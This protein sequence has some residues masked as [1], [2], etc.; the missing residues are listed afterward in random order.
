MEN[1]PNWLKRISTSWVAIGAILISFGIGGESFSFLSAI[2]SQDF[3]NVTL[4]TVGAVI[5]W[6]QY[7]RVNVI[8]KKLQTTVQ[9]LSNSDIVSY[10]INP[11]KI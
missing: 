8:S 7:I 2:F 6:Y 5:T 10:L 3:V 11:F 9:A 1:I 4:T